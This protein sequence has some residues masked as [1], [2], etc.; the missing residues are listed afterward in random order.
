M[1]QVGS[2][3]FP[4]LKIGRIAILHYFS[5]FVFAFCPLQLA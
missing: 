4:T 1:M 3:F 2:F 5:P